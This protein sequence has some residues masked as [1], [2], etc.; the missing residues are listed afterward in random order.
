MS[1]F[2]GKASTDLFTDRWSG[3]DSLCEKFQRIKQKKTALSPFIY[4]PSCSPPF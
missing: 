3:R 2:A 4:H 1:A